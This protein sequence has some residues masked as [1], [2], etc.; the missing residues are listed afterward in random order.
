MDYIGYLRGTI[1]FWKDDYKMLRYEVNLL[2]DVFQISNEL[3]KILPDT[4]YYTKVAIEW[5]GD[6]FQRNL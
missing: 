6:T 3:A 2:G 1:I 4:N 5:N